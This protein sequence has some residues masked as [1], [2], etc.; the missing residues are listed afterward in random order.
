MTNG[1]A[2]TKE[3][4]EDPVVVQAFGEANRKSPSFREDCAESLTGK[5]LL[6]AGCGPGRDAH[7]FAG[8]GFEVTAFDYSVAMIEAAQAASAGPNPPRFRVLDLRAVGE[9]FLEHSF[10]GAWVC[11]SLLHI[12]EPEVPAVLAGLRRVLTV[13]GRAMITLKGG[14]QGAALVTERKHGRVLQREFVFWERAPFEAALERAGFRVTGFE[15]TTQGTTGGQPT[16]WLRSTAEA[17]ERA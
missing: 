5:K 10:D 14:R 6:D 13:G 12:P 17:G 1:Q 9:S 2:L 4:Y 3:A 16:Q 8:L 7:F 15:T 11:A